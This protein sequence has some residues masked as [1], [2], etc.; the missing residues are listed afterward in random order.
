MAPQIGV[1]EKQIEAVLGQQV[2]RGRAAGRFGS[3]G[4]P[5]VPAQ[6]RCL[7][8][9]LAQLLVQLALIQAH[10]SGQLLQVVGL[11]Y[12]VLDLGDQR[13]QLPGG[14]GFVPGFGH[15]Q[16]GDD[17]VERVVHHGDGPLEQARPFAGVLPDDIIRV[18]A[19]RQD[20]NAYFRV[21]LLF[22]LDQAGR[23]RHGH[24]LLVEGVAGHLDSPQ[25]CHL[26]GGVGVQGQDQAVGELLD[27]PHVLLG[28]GRSQRGHHVGEPVL[29][30]HDDIHVALHHHRQVLLPDG[31]PGEVDAVEAAALVED[32]RLG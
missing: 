13:E 20:H 17:Q 4:R 14:L 12:P 31:C 21:Q 18:F 28:E 7:L 2:A 10:R 19:L 5:G 9:H 30:G 3:R 22:V 15:V 32:Q 8:R 23:C 25:R 27:Y 6:S 24:H 26:A 11:P 1:A 16:P 29:V